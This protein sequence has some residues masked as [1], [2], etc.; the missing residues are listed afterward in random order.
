MDVELLKT[1]I[2]LY[3]TRHFGKTAENLHLTTAG[4]SSRIKLLE[5]Q[6]NSPLFTRERNNIQPTTAGSALLS[7]AKIILENWDNAKQLISEKN[8]EFDNLKILASPGF[9]DSFSSSWVNQLLRD[10]GNLQ[11]ELETLNSKSAFQVL[12]NGNADLYLSVESFSH[13]QIMSEEI[14]H[15]T[16]FLAKSKNNPSGQFDFNHYIHIEWSQSF[17]TQF[18][19][20]HNEFRKPLITVSTPR[21]ARDL[22][23]HRP[24]CAY[25]SE[26]ILTESEDLFCEDDSKRFELGV[27]AYYRKSAQS[28]SITNLISSLKENLSA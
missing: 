3:Q 12:L 17:N 21:L 7:Y 15:L 23:K 5:E 22:L 26:K 18:E 6:L 4:V 19:A 1:F 10:H 8:N 20:S 11:L 13:P 27:Y 28:D 25:L 16:L 14:G 2:E 9:W 24:G